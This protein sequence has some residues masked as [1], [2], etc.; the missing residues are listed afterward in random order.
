MSIV[1]VALF[2]CPTLSFIEIFKTRG[3][4]K[5]YSPPKP[6]VYNQVLRE[7]VPWSSMDYGTHS[8]VRFQYFFNKS[9]LQI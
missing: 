8:L 5:I 7:R 1:S 3:T 6:S 2:E 4:S 9:I